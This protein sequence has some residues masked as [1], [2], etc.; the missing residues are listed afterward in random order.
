MPS[1]GGAEGTTTSTTITVGVDESIRAAWC[2]CM[3]KYN[4]VQVLSHASGRT[5]ICVRCGR[6]VRGKLPE[7]D[8]Q[9]GKEVDTSM[10]YHSVGIRRLGRRSVGRRRA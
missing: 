4:S 8:P 3:D 7:D 10:A 6:I 1:E 2:D 9:A 5:Q